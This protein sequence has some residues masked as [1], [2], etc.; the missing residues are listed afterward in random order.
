MKPPRGLARWGALLTTLAC[1]ALVVC[2]AHPRR[3]G[4]ALAKTLSSTGFLLVSLAGWAGA[5]GAQRLRYARCVLAAQCL[6]WL[7]DALLITGAPG[8][9][10]AGLVAFLLGHACYALAFLAQGSHL[11]SAA[12][13]GVPVAAAVAGAWAYLAPH[14]PPDMVLPVAAYLAVISGMVISAGAAVHAS[15]RPH[16]LLLGATLF[17]VSDLAVARERFVSRAFLNQAIGL[18][19]YYTAQLLLAWTAV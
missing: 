3:R 8:P 1:T 15:S 17:F 9:F 18:P 13:V 19:M 16:P 7:G 10:L 11:P 5:R 14:L 12:A 6:S 2:E 4:V